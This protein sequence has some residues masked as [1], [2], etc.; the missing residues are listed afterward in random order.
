MLPSLFIAHGA[1]TIVIEDN[2]YTKFLKNYSAG[3]KRPK[4][5]IVF[6]AH[7]EAS[8]QLIGGSPSYEMIYD[9]FGFPREL[10]S[11]TYDSASDIPTAQAI[12]KLLSE[13]NVP[14]KIDE[15]RGIDHGAWTILKLM[16]PDT[17]IPIITMSVNTKLMPE[18]QYE[19]GKSLSK[20]KEEDYLIICSGGIVHNFSKVRFNGS[21]NVDGWAAD[22][23]NW[24]MEKI[25][26]WDM[27]ELFNY[28]KLAPNAKLAV[29]RN[30]HFIN[31]LIALGTGNN[32]KKANLLKSVY[33]FGN[34]SLDFW[35]FE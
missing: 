7:W 26:K 28:E 33:Q 14:S 18:E 30:E 23:N 9:F 12:Q 17:D 5:I 25:Y 8:V 21:E 22:F 27:E 3:I 15:S 2:E 6:S 34:L 4:A 19:I 29:P 31:L 13:N 35:E 1:P 20:L 11:I 24:I 32:K 16:Y 10:Y